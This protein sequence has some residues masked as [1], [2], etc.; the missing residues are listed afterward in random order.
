MLIDR[1]KNSA[2]LLWLTKQPN[3]QL[4]L[5]NHEAL[6]LT[7]AFLFEEV[8]E[9]SLEKLTAVQVNLLENYICNGGAPTLTGLKRLLKQ[10]SE[11]V[12][13][14]LDYLLIDFTQQGKFPHPILVQK[15]PI[16]SRGL[17]AMV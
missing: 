4:I 12:Y 17:M 15:F 16:Q 5:G 9:E 13:G 1:G 3:M 10:D 6:L 8:T 11:L 2:L 14:I 7:C